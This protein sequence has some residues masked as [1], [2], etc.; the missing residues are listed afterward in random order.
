VRVN[1]CPYRKVE[2]RRGDYVDLGHVRFRFVEPG[3]D[4]V[5]ARDVQI[6]V[7]PVQRSGSATACAYA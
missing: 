5:F 4:F 6:T 2:L 1:G 3:E 7:V